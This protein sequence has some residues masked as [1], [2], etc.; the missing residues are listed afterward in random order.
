MASAAVGGMADALAAGD[1]GLAARILWLSLKLEWQKGVHALN[2][3]W[4]DVKDAFLAT[5]TEAVFGVAAIATNGWAALESGWIETVDVLADAWTLF[6]TGLTRTWNTAVGFI[7]QAWV[8]LKS[9][10]DS[11]V[12]VDAEVARINADVEQQNVAAGTARDQQL[13]Q[14]EQRRRD[15]L[16]GI[17][18][19][20]SGALSELDSMRESEHLRN[21]R[22][23]D[24]DLA[25]SEAALDAAR[26]EWQAALD[27]AATK[28]AATETGDGEGPASPG[29][30]PDL[31]DTLQQQLASVGRINPSIDFGLSEAQKQ[32][33]TL[34]SLGAGR[35]APEEQTA[36]NTQQMIAE[37][38]AQNRTLRD[39]LAQQKRTGIARVA[40]IG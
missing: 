12:D 27:A 31:V 24:A 36:K 19:Q 40:T 38:K 33:I 20:R 39:L 17:E 11:D 2:A 23:L 14:R 13:L 28:R 25:S 9:L 15:R 7:R 6:T 5:W 8:R 3:A 1:L 10:F 35:Q 30:P 32:A 22:G 37:L 18:A 26:R 16:A 34:Q 21:R 29:V 4:L